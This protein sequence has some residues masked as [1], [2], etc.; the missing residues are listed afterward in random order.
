MGKETPSFD[1]SS[2]QEGL[3]AKHGDAPTLAS[4]LSS[5][6]YALSVPVFLGVAYG[7][8]ALGLYGY[9]DMV[10]VFGGLLVAAIV[11][12]FTVMHIFTGT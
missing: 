6:L 9:R 8:F 11:L 2:E 4:Y 7:G 12:A 5:L 1:R 3:E 10:P